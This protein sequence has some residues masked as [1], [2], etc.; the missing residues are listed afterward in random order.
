M[1]SNSRPFRPR[2]AAKDAFS[3][4]E[5]MV[6]TVILTVT[7]VGTLTGLLQARRMTEGSIYVATATT[8]AQGYIEQIKNME[9]GLL[10]GSAIPELISQGADDFLLV[11]PLP[12]DPELGNPGTDLVNTRRID[13][14]NTPENLVDDL[15]IEFV[16]YIENI[17]SEANRVAEARRIILRWSYIDRTT[18]NAIGN[19]LY[20]IR[21][22]VPTF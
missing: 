21:S 4:V 12:A 11:S 20:S 18:G 14:N 3:L 19:T 15:E 13:I 22:R 7:G 8:V 16:A 10:D 1:K 6:A 5:V 2:F 9:F 17:T